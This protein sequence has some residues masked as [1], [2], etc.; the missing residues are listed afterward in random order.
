MLELNPQSAA[1]VANPTSPAKVAFL[2]SATGKLRLKDSAGVTETASEGGTGGTGAAVPT[3]GADATVG[4]TFA[5]VD[6]GKLINYNSASV[7][8]FTV[9]TDATL[10]LTASVDAVFFKVYI[11]GTGRADIVAGAGVTVR[12]YAGFPTPAQSV[13]QTCTRISANEWTVE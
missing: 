9:P 7:A 1:S 11:K 6:L 13:M 5:N 2:D 10:G 12:N 3:F 8:T 4:R